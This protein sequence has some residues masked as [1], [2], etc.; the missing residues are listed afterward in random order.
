M[1]DKAEPSET[2]VRIGKDTG[3]LLGILARHHDLSISGYVESYLRPMILQEYT[4]VM[5]DAAKSAKRELAA[6]KS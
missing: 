6:T 5:D 1:A 3:R 2:V 4:R